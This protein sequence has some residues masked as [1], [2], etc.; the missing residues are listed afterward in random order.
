[1]ST[2]PEARGRWGLAAGLAVVAALVGILAFLLARDVG[3]DRAAPPIE[4]LTVERI[5]LPRPD[6]VRVHVVNGGIDPVTIHQVMIDDAV[7]SFSI[8]PDPTIARLRNATISIPYP[9]VEGETHHVRLVSRNGI[10]FDADIAVATETPSADARW[11]L[12]LALLG[13]YIGVL[14]VALGLATYPFLKRLGERGIDFLLALTVGLLVFLG[15]DTLAEAQELAGEAAGAFHAPVLVWIVALV[16][17]V[18]LIAISARRRGSRGALSPLAIA[19]L[20]ALG[21]GLHN[22]GEGLAVGAA[23][24][25]GAVGLGTFLIVGFTLHNITEG[26]GIAAPLLRAEPRL[27]HFVALA[28]LAGGPAVLGAWIGGFVFDP[29][30]SA[31]FLA[32]GAGAI[33]QVVYEI[34]RLMV[35]ESK[36]PLGLWRGEIL[37]GA[38]LGLAIMYATALIVPA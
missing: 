25:T 6:L 26:I 22:L 15:V 8:E 31:V 23:L 14:P 16:T 35:I 9:W 36:G 37:A 20:I 13:L 33:L 30:W 38:G 3:L 11:I 18:G 5:E 27:R 29:F 19:F 12:Q 28:A 10:T 34:G 21:I 4:E 2:R 17:L 7:W 32:V 24:A 1:M